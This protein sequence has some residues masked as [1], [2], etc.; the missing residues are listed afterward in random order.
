MKKFIISTC[1]A[2]A[3]GATAASAQLTLNTMHPERPVSFGLRVGGNVS[4]TST[5][6]ASL[7]PAIEMFSPDWRGGFTAGFV[8]DLNIREYISV[9]PGIFYTSASHGSKSVSIGTD[10]EQPLPFASITSTTS[11]AHYIQIPILASLKLEAGPHIKL[12]AEAGPYFAWGFGGHEKYTVNRYDGNIGNPAFRPHKR[13]YFGHG[14]VAHSFD[15]GF[16]MGVGASFGKF[17][18]SAHYLAGCR[19]VLRPEACVDLNANPMLR[20]GVKGYNKMWQF[21]AGYNF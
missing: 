6:Q 1:M 16:K 8:A 9:Q 4:N 11:V 19:D 3:L 20:A 5:N 13:D 12:I 2:L 18:V 14:N 10:A 21:T 15:W 17:L 7:M